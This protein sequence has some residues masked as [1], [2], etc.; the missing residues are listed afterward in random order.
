[1]CLCVCVEVWRPRSVPP[2]LFFESGYFT[3]P[4]TYKL[5]LSASLESPKARSVS[6]SPALGTEACNATPILVFFLAQISWDPTQ[7]RLP[8]LCDKHFLGWTV[9]PRPYTYLHLN[10]DLLYERKHGT[11]LTE[12]S[13]YSF[14]ANGTISSVETEEWKIPSCTYT[15]S[16]LSI[17]LL[18]DIQA[19]CIPLLCSSQQ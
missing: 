19:G 7:L 18:V 11:C 12:S 8:G 9:F 13:F 3:W 2:S 4:R 17:R 15:T 16:S 14:P 1:M 5:S 10:L 6:A